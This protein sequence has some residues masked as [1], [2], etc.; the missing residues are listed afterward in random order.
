[1]HC[2]VT[3]RIV[4]LLVGATILVVLAVAVGALWSLREIAPE[5]LNAC[6]LDADCVLVDQ[7]YCGGNMG[8]NVANQNR[9]ER[10]L[11]L[12]RR[13]TR[14]LRPALMC[15][16]SLPREAYEARCLQAACRALLRQERAFLEFSAEPLLNTPITLALHYR[17]ADDVS[18]ARAAIEFAAP[19]LE[20]IDGSPTWEGSL[21]AGADGAVQLHVVATE[22][23]YYQVKGALQFERDGQH[24]RLEDVVHLEVDSTGATFGS[25]PTNRWGS[26][27]FLLVPGA[28]E[29]VD[30]TLGL[31]DSQLIISPEPER[32]QEAT[33]VYRVTPQVDL[34]ENPVVM[35]VSLPLQGTEI[36]GGLRRTYALQGWEVVD[37]AYPA[38]GQSSLDALVVSWQGPL[39][40]GQ[41]AEI[42]MTFRV[43]E[44]GW[45][46]VTG[47][48]FF[49]PTGMPGQHLQAS[50]GLELHVDEHRSYMI[51]VQ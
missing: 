23:G 8:I 36:Q 1:M 15:A 43:T 16:P 30:D 29:P 32:G 49:Q 11:Q 28:F 20:I 10:R 44:Y 48:V 18:R 39:V 31:V 5:D 7:G 50:S 41:T 24:V 14:L 34:G 51:P 47:H 3:S 35:Q 25:K 12:Q 22:A 38:G 4:R 26:E 19:G 33:L 40:R 6:E 42:K 37:V 45:G 9:W 13:I 27:G 46:K 17:V 2:L 21:R